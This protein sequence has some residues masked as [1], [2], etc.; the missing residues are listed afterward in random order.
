MTEELSRTSALADKH[1]ALGSGLEDW[2]G[3]GTAWTYDSDPEKEHD[4]V[5]EAAGMFD[6]SPLK[7]VFVRGADAQAT[8]DHLTTRDLSR[9]TPG[10][11]AYLCVLTDQGGIADD[12]NLARF[13]VTQAV[14]VVIDT[15]IGAGVIE[16][17]DSE[18]ATHGVFFPTTEYVVTQN[19]PVLIS[20]ATLAIDAS[21]FT[22]EGG[23]LHDLSPA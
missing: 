2:N 22:T 1:R 9:V 14:D 5:R 23:N 17:V 13:Q 18:I 20:S 19:A 15:E 21:M 3:M 10:K 8:L 16:G 11:A 12:A 6:M 7:K 4:A